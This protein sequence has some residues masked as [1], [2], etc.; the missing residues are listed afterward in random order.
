MF[1]IVIV[2]SGSVYRIEVQQFTYKPISS[3][4]SD[5]SLYLLLKMGVIKEMKKNLI[6]MYL[7]FD[8]DSI[9][10]SVKYFPPWNIYYSHNITHSYLIYSDTNSDNNNKNH[11]DENKQDLYF[12]S[13]EGEDI[14]KFFN[15]IIKEMTVRDTDN[16]KFSFINYNSKTGEF[17]RL[18]SMKYPES[19]II[20]LTDKSE[21]SK[22]AENELNKRNITNIEICVRN[23]DI[24]LINDLYNSPEFVRFQY[25]EMSLVDFL[26]TNTLSNVLEFYK[27]FFTLSM[28]SFIR[29]PSSQIISLLFMT[30][31]DDP[32]TD[33][34][35]NKYHSYYNI[36]RVLSRYEI[37]L[38]PR[39][40]YKY[41]QLNIIINTAKLDRDNSY[42]FIYLSIIYYLLI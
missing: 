16:G 30:F 41:S 4:T 29:I 19:T 3:I 36:Q 22:I 18:L 11:N 9:F 42:V 25:N 21:D 6:N 27:K 5:I 20:S 2:P 7:H 40:Y 32:S 10:S 12:Q 38:H 39:Q 1:I 37:A 23:S 26:N 14:E 34:F 17:S 31:F 28:S 35:W 15:V 24:S 13:N 8:F 33:I